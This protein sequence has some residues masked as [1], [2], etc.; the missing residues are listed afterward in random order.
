MS[1]D[2]HHATGT[3]N[4]PPPETH[5]EGGC[6]HGQAQPHLVVA[7]RDEDFESYLCSG[8]QRPSRPAADLRQAY[9]N[10][11]Q[12]ANELNLPRH[13]HDKILGLGETLWGVL[14]FSL[15]EEV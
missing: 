5:L 1:E 9:D 13:V 4:A 14:G 7:G 15:S 2:H 11:V 3:Q 12:V 10:L 6:E 8:D